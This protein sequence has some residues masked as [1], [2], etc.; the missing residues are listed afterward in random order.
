MIPGDMPQNLWIL[1]ER[2]R[3]N[4]DHAT[5]D[6]AFLNVDLQ[7]RTDPQPPADEGVFGKAFT[8]IRSS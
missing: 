6:I 1:V 5:T 3:I 2:F 8:G 4:A 7:F